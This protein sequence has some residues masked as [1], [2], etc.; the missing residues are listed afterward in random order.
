M[1]QRGGD[2]K[3]TCLKKMTFILIAIQTCF[4]SSYRLLARGHCS[5]QTL[6]DRE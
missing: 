6:L 2:K 3:A 1:F 4:R 5:A